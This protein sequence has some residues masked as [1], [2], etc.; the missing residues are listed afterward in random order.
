MVARAQRTAPDIVG[1]A[2]GDAFHVGAF[3][4]EVVWPYAYADD[5]GNADSLC[6]LV[7]YDGDDDGVCDFSALFTGDAEKDQLAEVMKSGA[8]SAVDILKVAHH[9]SKNAMTCSQV[10]VLHPSIALIGVGEGNRYG[11]PAPETVDMLEENGC[12]VY[13]SDLDG[14]VKCSL[15]PDSIAVSL[16]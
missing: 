1:L 9:G 12:R 14:Q 16:Q 6:L 3:T 2:Y 10:A 8:V 13:R 11:H 15:A 5:G 7:S 4:A